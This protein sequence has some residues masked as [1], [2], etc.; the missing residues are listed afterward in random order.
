MRRWTAILKVTFD[1][2]TYAKAMA[3]AEAARQNAE[4]DLHTDE[5]D[6]TSLGVIVPLGI[7]ETR[8]ET[9]AIL[10]RARN[11]LIRVGDQRCVDVAREVDMIAE[12]I[13]ERAADM[14][15][16]KPYDYGQFMDT[17]E[18]VLKGLDPGVD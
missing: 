11:S 3:A 1:A 13:A 4:L 12:I 10:R 5:G 14:D 18:Q 15:Y 7:D 9:V 17:V 6:F 2:E 8:E 16:H